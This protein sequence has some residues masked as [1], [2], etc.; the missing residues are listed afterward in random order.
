M[1][2]P[3]IEFALIIKNV[4]S[5]IIEKKLDEEYMHAMLKKTRIEN[6]AKIF[7]EKRNLDHLELIS[8][9]GIPDIESSIAIV[10]LKLDSFETR[11]NDNETISDDRSRVSML[12]QV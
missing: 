4:F 7:L 11:L 10:I 6:C 12:S 2:A 9:D 5:T 3:P 8:K 1:L